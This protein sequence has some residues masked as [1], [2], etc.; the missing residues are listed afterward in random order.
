M[1]IS[2]GVDVVGCLAW[3]IMDNLEWSS[4]EFS[5]SFLLGFWMRGGEEMV[6]KLFLLVSSHIRPCPLPFPIPPFRPPF[7][8]HIFPHCPLPRPP[9]NLRPPTTRLPRKIR[10]AIRQ[11]HDRRSILQSEFFRIR[12][13]V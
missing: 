6:L 2:E 11:S 13:C 12:Q 1:A 7:P 3:S 10:H 5:S 9:T 4:G 8:F